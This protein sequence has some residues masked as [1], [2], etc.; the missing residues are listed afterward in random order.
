MSVSGQGDSGEYERSAESVE[1]V[2]FVV[3]GHVTRD[4]LPDGSWQLGGATYC[5]LAALRLGWRVGL[6]TSGPPE[7]IDRVRQ[8]LS[9]ALLTAV[10]AK[11]ATTFANRYD[12]SGMRTQHLRGRAADLAL[13][14]VPQA[15][16]SASITLLAPFAQEIGPEM[17][18]SLTGGLLAATPQGWLRRWRS[19]GVVLPCPPE[20]VVAVLPHLHALIL[21]R[22]D[23]VPGK[24]A[25]PEERAGL[26]ENLLAAAALIE[27]WAERGP[28]I[29][30]T[31]GA[32]GA[33]LLRAGQPPRHCRAY[34]VLE[35]DPTGAGDI[36]A[37]AFLTIL[38]ETGDPEKAGDFANRAAALRIER[39]GLAGVPT[40][41]EIAERW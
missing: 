38:H 14:V 21:S 16:R 39:R 24:H 23:L 17:A 12:A 2:D 1:S 26:P 10:P 30:E 15:W 32:E 7:V 31:R 27:G 34:R 41:A 11:E 29:A 4:D 33:R 22:E 3:I 9:G 20:K 5:A 19:D 25:T 35:A 13:D 36:F 37:V 6:V 18:A 28:M 8:T 40:R